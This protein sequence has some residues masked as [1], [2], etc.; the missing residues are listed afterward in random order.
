[1]PSEDSFKQEISRTLGICHRWQ[2]PA[3]TMPTTTPARQQ[4]SGHAH[5]RRGTKA[6]KTL[7]VSKAHKSKRCGNCLNEIKSRKI[8]HKGK[9]D[10][11]ITIAEAERR[12]V[13]PMLFWCLG[14]Q[15]GWACF[16]QVE[17][18]FEGRILYRYII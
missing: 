17:V 12:E 13:P 15:Q 14:Q 8:L 3:S 9:P 10:I 7:S 18:R 11:E 4:P 5:S 1:M 16:L 6:P 2:T